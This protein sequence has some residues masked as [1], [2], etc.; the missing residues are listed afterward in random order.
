MNEAERQRRVER[1]V[2]TALELEPPDRAAF[3]EALPDG[4]ELRNE[5]QALVASYEQGETA[6]GRTLESPSAEDGETVGQGKVTVDRLEFRNS[7]RVVGSRIGPYRIVREIGSGGMGVVYEAEQEEPV[8]RKVAL[9]LIKWGMDTKQVIARFESERQAL[10]LMDHP[11]IAR[12]FDAGTTEQGRLYFA[13]E[14]VKGIPINDYCDQTS[15]DDSG[16]AGAVHTGV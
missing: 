6:A 13:M 5:V 3:L 10:A 16:T 12:V 8:R 2:R 1:L 11:Y 14:Y 9:K 4:P 7:D 15:T